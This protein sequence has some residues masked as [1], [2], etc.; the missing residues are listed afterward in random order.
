[1]QPKGIKAA[2]SQ[3]STPGNEV[4]MQYIQSGIKKACS[5]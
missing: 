2:P 3:L 4:D 1:M 5:A